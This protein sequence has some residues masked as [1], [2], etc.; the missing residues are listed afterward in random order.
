M[1]DPT[2][3]RDCA[4]RAARAR[5]P[6][7]SLYRCGGCRVIF[8]GP[9][10]FGFGE[11]TN[12]ELSSAC[13]LCGQMTDALPGT[14]TEEGEG[15]N[16]RIYIAYSEAERDA[17]LKLIDQLRTIGNKAEPEDV[18]QTIERL[19]FL[20]PVADYVRAHGIE[21][22]T[23]AIAVLAWVFPSPLHQADEAPRR[24]RPTSQTRS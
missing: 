2:A 6:G 4:I 20:Q 15:L 17:A 19:P 16:R 18:A 14:L 23:L 1:T 10:V 3:N 13:P 7:Q 5:D 12:V 22:L 21:A 11:V 24:L 9:V 8:P